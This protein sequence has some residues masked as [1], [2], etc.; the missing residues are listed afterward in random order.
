MCVCVCLVII[1]AGGSGHGHKRRHRLSFFLESRRHIAVVVVQRAD[2]IN[3]WCDRAG[4]HDVTDVHVGNSGGLSSGLEVGRLETVCYAIRTV[5]CC[6]VCDSCSQ[7][8][9]HKYEQFLDLYSVRFRLVFVC[10]WNGLVCIFVC[11]SRVSLDHFGFAF[12]NLVFVVFRF[13]STEP[14]D[15]LGRTAPKWPILCR[16]GT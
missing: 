8:H 12:S 6:V 4:G 16:V 9:A 3:F 15:W 5:P 10:F 14:R 13:F 1:T 2:A 11:S 7:R